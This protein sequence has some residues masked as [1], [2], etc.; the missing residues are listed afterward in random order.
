M[1][2]FWKGHVGIMLDEK[3]FIHANSTSMNVIGEKLSTVITR[4]EKND[5]G[6]IEVILERVNRQSKP[7]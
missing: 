2:I 3:Y 7:L 4:H 5:V 6:D 1:L